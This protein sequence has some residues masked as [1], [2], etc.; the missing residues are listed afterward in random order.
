MSEPPLLLSKDD[1][2]DGLGLG[3][4]RRPDWAKHEIFLSF[5]SKDQ[6]ACDFISKQLAAEG[7]EPW[8]CIPGVKPGQD[9]TE[10]I[11]QK[12][13]EARCFILLLSEH[14]LRSPWV[15]SEV[16]L[17]FERQQSGKLETILVFRLDDVNLKGKGMELPLARYQKVNEHVSDWKDDVPALISCVKEIFE[18]TIP[19][20]EPDRST[21]R[22]RI[23]PFHYGSVVPPA[24]FIDREVELEAAQQYIRTRQSFLIVG[25]RRAGKSS[26]GQKLIHTLMSRAESDGTRILGSYLD[27]QQYPVL[28]V[29]R[30]LGHTLLNLIG[31]VSRQ[32]FTCKFSTLIRQDPYDVHPE[33]RADAPF[34]DL[35]HLYQAVFKR[36]HTSKKARPV[37]L[38]QH[39]FEGY[40]KDLVEILRQK[41]WTDI[42][43]FYDEANRLPVD[44]SLEFLAWN[45]DALNRA[46]IVSIYAASPEMAEKFKDWSDREI[47]IGPFEN[48]EDMLRLLSRYYFDLV[49]PKGALPVTEDAIKLIW[50]LSLRVPYLIQQISG[51]SFAA[52]SKEGAKLVDERHV[53]GAH[54]DL[55]F[56]KP[57]MFIS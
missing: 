11:V 9:F 22:V 33:L 53:K 8:W 5:S 37:D 52:A 50:E 46:G 40:I 18:T 14:A 49:S 39:E 10:L 26:F 41:S 13:G 48:V 34:N 20:P 15:K 6:A 38:S 17:A 12:L 51:R 1:G 4:P 45:V 16:A 31:E 3:R 54:D 36:T 30:F 32:V 35:L 21:V 29:N 28:D 2:S 24:Y 42:F 19:E 27:L 23:P 43:I 7:L 55:R 25:N 47:H 44:L 56:S 57:E